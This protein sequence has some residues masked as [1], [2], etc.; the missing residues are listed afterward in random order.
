MRCTCFNIVY[1]PTRHK[2]KKILARKG[3][4]PVIVSPRAK[5][6]PKVRQQDKIEAGGDGAKMKK[7]AGHSLW[8]RH[9]QRARA[10]GR[11]GN[12][13]RPGG[14]P[15]SLAVPRQKWFRII[16]GNGTTVPAIIFI[17]FL[18]FSLTWYQFKTIATPLSYQ[19]SSFTCP[20]SH[21]IR[22]LHPELSPFFILHLLHS[23]RNIHLREELPE[24]KISHKISS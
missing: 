7:P 19:F 2:E 21:T 13:G 11:Q 3:I 10:S 23:I 4:G 6:T 8:L 18:S 15:E 22:G 1:K 5:P 9:R 16:F 20:R 24:N 17:I 12:Q 14:K